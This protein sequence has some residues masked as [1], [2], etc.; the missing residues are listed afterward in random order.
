[1]KV[2]AYAAREA[3]AS[4]E[5]Y[6]YEAGPLGPH[7]VDIRVTHCGVCHTDVGMI[8]DEFGLARFPV[9]AGHEVVGEVAAIG[10]EVDPVRL[11]IGAR[12]GLG[13]IAGSCFRCEWCLRGLHQHCPERDDQVLRG[14]RG[15]FAQQVRAG[16]WRH[17]HPIPDAIP[18]AAAA[19]LLCAG[20]TVFAPLRRHR[21]SPTDRVAVVGIGGLGHLAVQFFAAWGCEVTAISSSRA[22]EADA[23]QFG[24]AHYLA[25]REEGALAAAAGSFDLILSTVSADL[26]WDDYLAMLRPAGTLSVVG[27]PPGGITAGAMALL[28]AAKSISGGVPGSIDDTR[29]MLSFAA[30]HDI[31]PMIETFPI[32]DSAAALDQVRAG[33]ARYRAVLEF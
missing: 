4:L 11:P 33:T 8:D 13:A 1:M 32:A 14:D 28:P 26:P 10:T 23:R 22:K 9:V 20:T 24:A 12:V 2:V 6:E 21:V 31:R 29:A 19:P 18:S 5:R 30:R 15:G 17:V 7:E 3:A 27:V 16:D 25:S